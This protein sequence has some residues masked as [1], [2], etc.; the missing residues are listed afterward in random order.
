MIKGCIVPLETRNLVDSGTLKITQIV[1]PEKFQEN[2]VIGFWN[3]STKKHIIIQ[4]INNRWC[5]CVSYKGNFSTTQEEIDSYKFSLANGI[6]CDLQQ[7]IDNISILGNLSKE[8]EVITIDDSWVNQEQSEKQTLLALPS[9]DKTFGEMVRITTDSLSPNT[10]IQFGTTE[11]DSGYPRDAQYYNN[12]T[13]DIMNESMDGTSKQTVTGWYYKYIWSKTI[14]GL[15]ITVKSTG[16]KELSSLK[17]GDYGISYM[18]FYQPV[19]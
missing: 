1:S 3:N 17:P 12:T 8:D 16:Y 2:D 19:K 10:Q 11:F 7:D 4:K 14:P 5:P 6:Q 9:M 13:L 15:P 18:W